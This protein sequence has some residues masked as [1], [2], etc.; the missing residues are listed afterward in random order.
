MKRPIDRRQNANNQ[1]VA[2]SAAWAL[3]NTGIWNELN[4]DTSSKLFGSIFIDENTK[5]GS[6]MSSSRSFMRTPLGTSISVIAVVGILVTVFLAWRGLTPGHKS[7]PELTSETV[8]S[9]EVS[10]FVY[11]ATPESVQRVT[12]TSPEIIEELIG[13]FERTPISEFKGSKESLHGNT[14]TV[15]RFNL[16]NG[17]S[18]DAMWVFESNYNSV[19][20]WPDGT[21]NQTTFGRPI[22]D[23]YG[24]LG[25]VEEVPFAE[26]PV[27]GAE[28]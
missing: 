5:K 3:G 1:S 9:V 4:K 18:V 17:K 14:A 28:R 16:A 24:P 25:E 10:E 27:I 11:G 21:V 26:I 7:I 22:L 2:H 12:I 13:P 23:F 15:F 8:S 20:F 19:F 6:R